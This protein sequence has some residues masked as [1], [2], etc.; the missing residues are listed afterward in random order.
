MTDTTLTEVAR[1]LL[2]FNLNASE[3]ESLVVL[4]DT[5]TESIGRALFEAGTEIGLEAGLMTISPRKRSGQEPPAYATEAMA[6][7]DIVVCPAS[8]SFTHTRARERAADSGA[9]VATMPGITEAMFRDGA[10]SAD[11]ERVESLTKRV[12]SA[13]TE[14]NSATIESGGE[15][16]SVSLEGR[17]GIRSDGLLQEPGDWGNLP[18]G[19][20]YTAPVEGTA[21]GTLVFDAGIVGSGELGEPLYVTVEDGEIVNTDGATPPSVF[22]DGPDCARQA[23]ELGIGTN[24][25]AKI[26][27]TTLE[28]EKV[29]GTCHVAFG[30]NAGFGG[31]IECDSHVDGIIGEPT[32][33]FDDKPILAAGEIQL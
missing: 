20:A 25:S 29:Y 4:T 21:S 32:V 7:A 8:T 24:P 15:T 12:A 10:V 33:Y 31:T 6:A 16:F 1:D 13:L 9:R 3:G 23:C 22:V 28:D 26:I 17:D 14:A 19:E 18:S 2:S 27:G 30:D 11:Y 5:E